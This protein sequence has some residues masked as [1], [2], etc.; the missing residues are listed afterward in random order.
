MRVA[1]AALFLSAALTSQAAA[2]SPIGTWRT[3]PNAEGAYADVRLAPCANGEN[4][5]CGV[6]ARVYDSPAGVP[7]VTGRVIIR[8]M[9]E[10]GGRWSGGTV[11]APDEDRTYRARLTLQA[12]S[13]RVEGCVLGGVIC[14]GQTW[15][16]LE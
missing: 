11:W 16:R 1:F 5:L 13:L 15:A 6:I 2:Q 10:S 8:D 7:D 9:V 12:D 3:P 4:T 14:R